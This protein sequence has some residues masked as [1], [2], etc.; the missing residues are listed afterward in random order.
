MKIEFVPHDEATPEDLQALGHDYSLAAYLLAKSVKCSAG[1]DH[2]VLA[3]LAAGGVGHQSENGD[4]SN[5][6]IELDLEPDALDVVELL[7]IIMPPDV[8][9][10]VLVEGVSIHEHF[11]ELDGEAFAGEEE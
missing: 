11:E 1:L 9:K 4:D 2:S 5:R 10:D 6:R 8:A 7:R 3:D